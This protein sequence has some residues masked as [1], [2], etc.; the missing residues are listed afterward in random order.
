MGSTGDGIWMV[1]AGRASIYADHFRDE[2]VVAIG[3]GELRD[4]EADAEREELKRLYARDDP[5]ASPGKI[6]NVVGQVVRFL[7]EMQVGDRVTTYDA[8]RREYLLGRIES[9][10]ERLADDPEHTWARDV[11]WDGHVSRD[12]LTQPTR[13]TLGA[14]TTLF[15]ISG[16]AAAELLRKAVPL[17]QPLSEVE[18]EPEPD[19]EV[20][21]DEEVDG[22]PL[23]NDE[24]MEKA[25]GLIEDQLVRLDWEEMQDLVAGILRAMGYKTE[26]AA[27]GPDRGVD[28]F[29]SPDGLGLEEPRIFV[30]VKH[31]PRT[32]I[33]GPDVRSFLG[34]RQPGDRC[35]YVSTGG[36]TKDARYEADRA[37]TPLRLVALPKLRNLLLQH[38]ESLD[39]DVK[40]L[41]PLKRIYWPVD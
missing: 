15:L 11:R 16:G 35:L 37:N 6:A 24:V 22:W 41:V 9:E 29:A 1:R 40:T 13:N 14:S 31:R 10:P 39:P 2:C 25:E 30:E 34:G 36:F 33:G 23:S 3:F 38:Y 4:Y 27:R 20:P 21:G 28:I 19:V 5:E 12:T 18:P 17:D 26:V 32:P 7:R 8:D